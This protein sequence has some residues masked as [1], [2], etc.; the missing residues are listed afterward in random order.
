MDLRLLDGWVPIRVYWQQSRAMVDWCYLGTRR[1]SEPFFEL[2]IQKCLW[3]PFN[4]L[5]RYQ[6]SIDVL[7]E[8][9]EARP[10]V[11]PT[12]FIFH[13]SRCGSTLVAQ[14]LAAL[15]ENIVISE[16]GPI[17]TVLRAN[18]RDPSATDERRI[19]WLR[20]LVSALGQA[21]CGTERCLFIKFDSWS[22]IDLPLIRRAFPEVPSIFLYRD[23]VEVMAS[24]AR[25]RGSQMLP[26]LLHPSSLGL[27]A[28]TIRQM[29]LDEYCARVLAALCEAAARHY[30][31]GGARLVDYRQL[32]DAVWSAI[33]DHFGVR[34][35]P[36]EV[37]RMRRVAQFD[38]K[39]PSLTFARDSAAKR[40]LATD[41]IR[42]LADRWVRP[43]Y[44][45]LEALN[46]IEGATDAE[47]S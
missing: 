38:A 19:G 16:A 2:T 11:P 37:E 47:E 18:L 9:R 39:H 32:P 41:E 23:P 35:T 17:D 14:M 12:G 27:D 22:V 40:Q 3:Q 28:A 43:F 42:A 30:R 21:R 24:Q 44:D 1:L 10:G 36:E 45:R 8:L 6:T 25:E 29:S 5:F 31:M 7:D 46:D 26:G 13:M 34:Y 33:A 15:P 4:V 20:W